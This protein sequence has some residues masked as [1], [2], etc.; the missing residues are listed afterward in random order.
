VL[1]RKDGLFTK[2]AH[3]SS[4]MRAKIKA[5]VT[6]HWQTRPRSPAII[7]ADKR[8][9]EI[10]EWLR[11]KSANALVGFVLGHEPYA[12][13]DNHQHDAVRNG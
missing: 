2:G 6:R 5:G 1:P 4:E 8:R 13:D 10:D 12:V 3:P 7:A 9:A 11:T